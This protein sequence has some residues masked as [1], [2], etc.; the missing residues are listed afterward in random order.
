MRDPA[1]PRGGIGPFRWD[2]P[3]VTQEELDQEEADRQARA[4][5][6]AADAERRRQ[7]RRERAAQEQL[8]LTAPIGQEAEREEMEVGPV[9]PRV[10]DGA[11]PDD[12]GDGPRAGGPEE[13]E[14][15]AAE[16]EEEE[17]ENIREDEALFSD[18]EDEIAGAI[19]REENGGGDDPSDDGDE[20]GGR[21]DSEEEK[22]EGVHVQKGV[23][24]RDVNREHEGQELPGFGKQAFTGVSDKGGPNSRRMHLTPESHPI[25]STKKNQE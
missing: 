18:G 5:A 21:D 13:E 23:T 9:N 4:V 12:E 24:W 14:A 11:G 1:P 25:E 2:A 17:A 8:I 10:A 3:P 15:A 22:E 6:A 20:A 7:E 16:Q 19:E